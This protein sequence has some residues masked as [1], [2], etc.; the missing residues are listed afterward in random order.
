MGNSKADWSLNS[1][2]ER[3]ENKIFGEATTVVRRNVETREQKTVYWCMP[4]QYALEKILELKL[5]F[6]LK[7]SS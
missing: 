7:F 3:I 6:F 4:F 1:I 5:F 2:L